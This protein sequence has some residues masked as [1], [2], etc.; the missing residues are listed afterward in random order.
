MKIN[1]VITV[2]IY[3]FKSTLLD[4]MTKV[5]SYEILSKLKCLKILLEKETRTTTTLKSYLHNNNWKP[6]MGNASV[7]NANR[8]KCRCLSHIFIIFLSCSTLLWCR[9]KPLRSEAF[10]TVR[11]Q[12][13]ILR[14]T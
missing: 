4:E 13:I 12:L 9:N 2:N 10:H 3:L 8:K 11:H 14:C 5:W 7:T 1:V 6:S